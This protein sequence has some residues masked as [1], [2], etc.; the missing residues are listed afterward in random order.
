LYRF[1]TSTTHN[2]Q[3]VN[4][5]L[6]EKIV[7]YLSRNEDNVESMKLW[8]VLVE[9]CKYR[10]MNKKGVEQILTLIEDLLIESEEEESQTHFVKCHLGAIAL[11]LGNLCCGPI[12]M[13]LLKKIDGISL[14]LRMYQLMKDDNAEDVSFFISNYVAQENG[15]ES[16][17]LY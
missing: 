15:Y 4:P 8:W 17:G 9:H 6:L 12:E 16:L 2:F 1:C 13:G 14:I 5:E 3:P 11:C 10:K 7:D